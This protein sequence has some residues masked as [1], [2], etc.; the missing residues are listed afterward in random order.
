[1]AAARRLVGK[2]QRAAVGHLRLCY[3]AGP[4]GYTVQRTI[5]ALDGSCVVVAPSLVP[6]KPGDRIKTDRRDA[7]KLAEL[8]RAGL[9]TEVHPPPSETRRFAIC[10]VPG[11]MPM[12]IWSSTAGS[13]A[14]PG[15]SY[16]RHSLTQ[17]TEN[18]HCF[19]PSR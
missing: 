17:R 15:G 7:R 16:V 2:L 4:C 18:A 3:E 1:V 9:L 19:S 13:L 14:H 6:R 8:L 10:A 5:Q 12:R 11:S